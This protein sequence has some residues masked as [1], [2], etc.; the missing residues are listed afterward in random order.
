MHVVTLINAHL[1]EYR[2][3]TVPVPTVPYRDPRRAAYR[4]MCINVPPPDP[5][6]FE[7]Q[8]PSMHFYCAT[9]MWI[10]TSHVQTHT[11]PFHHYVPPYKHTPLHF[12]EH[13]PSHH[14]KLS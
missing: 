14:A 12:T 9:Q 8:L 11:P 13:T 5:T 1:E 10:S 4:R 2:R 6:D 7:L 3:G